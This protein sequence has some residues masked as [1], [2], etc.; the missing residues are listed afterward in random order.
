MTKV[1]LEL[2]PDHGMFIFFEKGMRGVVSYIS[3]NYSKVNDKYLKSYM[4]MQFLGF[5]QQ[6]DSNG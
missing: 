6:A 5:F 3:N 4:I 1:E 2:I